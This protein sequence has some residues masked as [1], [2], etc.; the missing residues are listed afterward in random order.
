[1]GVMKHI[2]HCVIVNSLNTYIWSCE[3]SVQ[4][5]VSR[6]DP[7]SGMKNPKILNLHLQ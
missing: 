5:S 1:M 7:V 3:V 2:N 4:P 6:C